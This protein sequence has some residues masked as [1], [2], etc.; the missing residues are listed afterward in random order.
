MAIATG[1]VYQMN[2][3]I[4]TFKYMKKHRAY[5]FIDMTDKRYNRA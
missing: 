5:N 2:A 4:G 1:G 3:N